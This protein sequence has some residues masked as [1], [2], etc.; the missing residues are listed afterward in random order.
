MPGAEIGG[1]LI[2]EM[3]PG[4]FELILGAKRDPQFGPVLI[5]GTGGLYA[6]AWHDVSYG[7]APLQSRDAE[8]M[9]RQAR[10]YPILQGARGEKP[11]DIP[12]LVECLLRLS[13]FMME[14]DLVEEMD[15]NPFKVFHKGGRAVDARVIL[16]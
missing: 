6:E 7:I 12:Y 15:I 13:Q 3:I 2:Q 4:G 11:Y 10:C 16:H 9:I 14:M 5:F 8:R 1:F